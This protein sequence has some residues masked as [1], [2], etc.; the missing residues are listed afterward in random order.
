MAK[1]VL[2]LLLPEQKEHRAAVADD[3]IQISTNEAD[4]L[5]VVT[6]KGTEASL[7]YAHLVL[8]L[9]QLTPLFCIVY[10]WILS[11]QTAG[12]LVVELPVGVCVAFPTD[13]SVLRTEPS[14]C[15]YFLL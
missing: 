1:F 10:G 12:A 8:Y 6:V 7:S 5:K 4:L 15:I 13:C 2:W 9:L 11:G 14:H 3:L